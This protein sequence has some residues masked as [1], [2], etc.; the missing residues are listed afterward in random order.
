MGTPPIEIITFS[1]EL[2]GKLQNPQKYLRSKVRKIKKLWAL[3]FEDPLR[4]MLEAA[5]DAEERLSPY[6]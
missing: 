2:E 1:V 3:G 6:Q 4:D 5:M